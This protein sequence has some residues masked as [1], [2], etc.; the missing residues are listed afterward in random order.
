MTLK[1]QWTRAL[2]AMDIHHLDPTCTPEFVMLG[3][4]DEPRLQLNVL[5]LRDANDQ[6][7]RIAKQ[8]VHTMNLRVWPGHQLA[9]LFLACAWA[10]FFQHEAL[11]HVLVDGERLWDPHRPPYIYDH[12]FRTGMPVDVVPET[13]ERTLALVMGADNARRAMGVA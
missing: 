7:R 3:A 9:Q 10:T 4:D 12:G 6:E 11:E 8:V 5:N 13:I 1:Q 2:E